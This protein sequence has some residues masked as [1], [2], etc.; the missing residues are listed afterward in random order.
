METVLLWATPA[1][2][3]LAVAG[4][5]WW[6]KPGSAA[7][8]AGG[9][10]SSPGG[11][12]ALR[13]SIPAALAALISVTLAVLAYMGHAS[14][15]TSDRALAGAAVAALASAVA[16]GMYWAIGRVVRH[17]VTLAGLWVVA[18]MPLYFY[19]FVVFLWVATYTQCGPQSYECP[20]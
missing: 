9:A 14:D 6:T 7:L 3:T 17:L 19:A 18:L 13:R 16:L 4:A 12:A 11:R 5:A 20:V 15:V 1:V 10:A 2:A 8:R